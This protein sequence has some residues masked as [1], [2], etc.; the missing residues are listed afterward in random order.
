MRGEAE[1]TCFELVKA[2]LNKDVFFAMSYEDDYIVKKAFAE[3]VPNPKQ[4]EFPDFV[5]DEGIIEHFQVTSSFENRKGSTM[6]RE[7]NDINRD[8]QNRARDAAENLSEGQITIH[9]VETPPYWHK[10][11]SYENYVDSFKGNFER[12]IESLKKYD[13]AKKQRIFM[14]EYS[15]SALRMSKKYA[16]DLM[17]EV[18]YGDLLTRE[19]PAYRISRDI[20]MLRYI[21]DKQDMVDF[22]VF[23][24][25]NC[26]H[27]A[28]VDVIKTQN[29]LEIVKLLHEGY[30]FNCAMVGSSQFGIGVS[31]PHKEGDADI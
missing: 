30:D 12:H 8:F 20:D 16:S 24:N 4:S 23:V 27:V 26:F 28:F 1:K 7:K 21:H 15:D 22:V 13:G 18:S 29:A 31:V 17:L 19:N 5:F 3:A 11:H 6:A 25:K 14:I 9:S 2:N 10:R